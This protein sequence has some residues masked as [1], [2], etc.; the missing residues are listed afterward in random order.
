[1]NIEIWTLMITLGFNAAI[2]VRVSNELGAYNPKAAKMSILV[3]VFMSTL[4]GIVF[5]VAIIATKDYFPM[6]FSDKAEV[7]NETSKLGYFLAATIFLNSIQ[8]V[9]H[10]VAVGA[11]IETYQVVKGMRSNTLSK[12][13]WIYPKCCNNDV[14]HFECG[15]FVMRHMLELIKLDIVNSFEQVL[16]MDKPYSS[17][18]IDD[19]RR[20]WAKCFLD[21]IR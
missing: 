4:F 8:P 12:P 2:S 15:L 1:M 17:D 16:H 13:K 11:A 7:I 14:L 5:T 10:G 18:D 9:L 6:L 21:D 20:S 19:V 3:A